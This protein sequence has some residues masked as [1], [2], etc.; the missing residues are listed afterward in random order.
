MRKFSGTVDNDL[1]LKWPVP[2]DIDLTLG[3]K[4]QVLW[5]ITEAAGPSSQ[6]IDF[7]LAGYSVGPGDDIDGT[8]GTAVASATASITQAQNTNGI[9]ALSGKVTVTNLARGET[10]FLNLT[11]KSAGAEADTYPEKLGV[12]EVRIFYWKDKT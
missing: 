1:T 8:F 2:K 9:T 3:I 12:Y 6:V 10:A 5:A 4:Y 11:R 7:E